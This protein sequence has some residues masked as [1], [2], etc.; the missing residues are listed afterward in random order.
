LKWGLV[1]RNV[2]TLGDPPRIPRPRVHALTPD[3][4]RTLLEAVRGE[5]F[6]AAM[7]WPSHWECDAGRS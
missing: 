3:E 1:A 6:E 5:R 4:A 7:F 2:A